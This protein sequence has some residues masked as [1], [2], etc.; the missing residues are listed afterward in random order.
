[1]SEQEA[2]S[3]P[4]GGRSTPHLLA[5]R[6]QAAFWSGDGGQAWLTSI[7]YVEPELEPLG[8]A[9][10]AVLDARP[11][12]S[13]LDVGCGAAATT[14]ALAGAVSPGGKVVGVD[15]SPALLE[16]ARMRL[17]ADAAQAPDGAAEWVRVGGT[18]GPR[19]WAGV[20]GGAG[21]GGVRVGSNTSTVQFVHADAQVEA[22]GG[23]FD[24]VFSRFGVMFFADPVAAFGTLRSATV[25]GGR[26]TFVCW[27]SVENNPWFSVPAQAI[28]TT[29]GVP[30]QPR[31]PPGAPGPFAFGEPDRLRSIL[32]NA[33]WAQLDIRP[34]HD[35]IELD[36]DGVEHRIEMALARVLPNPRGEPEEGEG[37]DGRL[38]RMQAA[39]RA[40]HA[41]AAYR[42]GGRAR[43]PRA[44]WIVTARNREP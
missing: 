23:P 37:E 7:D 14:L 25:G 18:A 22:P 30:E 6:E 9:A 39:D 26:L 42:D 5:N 17:A 16:L 12:E 11:G 40:R 31:Q 38:L 1:M 10:M 28:L 13:V 32:E 41:M 19:D 15:L 27:Q 43:F 24:A 29:P 2:T 35:Q 44:A 8:A 20:E 34:H 3:T 36:E 33:G 4:S 21:G